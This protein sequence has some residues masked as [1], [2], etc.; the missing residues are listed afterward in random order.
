M[1]QPPSSTGDV[2]LIPID[3]F[4]TEKTV[5]AAIPSGFWQE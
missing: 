1:G 3:V 2:Q 5:G 4:E